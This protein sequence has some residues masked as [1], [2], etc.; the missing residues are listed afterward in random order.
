V[1]GPGSASTRNGG[2]AGRV[3]LYVALGILA[4]LACIACLVAIFVGR[5][6]SAIS[7]VGDERV[8]EAGCVTPDLATFVLVGDEVVLLD[9]ATGAVRTRLDDGFMEVACFPNGEIAA[10]GGGRALFLP[11]RTEHVRDFTPGKSMVV[12]DRQLLH[13]RRASRPER[14]RSGS[15]QVDDGPPIVVV[16]MLGRPG[17]HEHALRPELFAGVGGGDVDLFQ[18]RALGMLAN[19]QL[20]VAAGFSPEPLTDQGTPRAFAD[21]RHRA[22]FRVDVATGAVAPEGPPLPSD[23]AFC[24]LATR[25]RPPPALAVSRDGSLAAC[26]VTPDQS[27]ALQVIGVVPATGERRFSTRL[28]DS[29]EVSRLAVSATGDLVAVGAI[30]L[31]GSES[32]ILVLDAAGGRTLFQSEPTAG[33][34]HVLELLPDG[35]LVS[36]VDGRVERRDARTGALRWST[37]IPEP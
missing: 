24:M 22:F 33:R 21:G 8:Y 28:A 18:A 12:A 1:T 26:V 15:Y 25:V 30:S 13:E 31:A 27:G 16:E 17:V 4:L 37:D 5:V 32:C 11:D 2:G 9:A 34:P 29:Y 35:S 3:L 19:G 20:L 23:V 6:W 14:T 7:G 36:A 10:L